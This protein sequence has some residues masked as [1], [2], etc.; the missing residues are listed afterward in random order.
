MSIDVK[1]MLLEGER[2]TLECK[3][4]SRCVPGSVWN[5]YSAFANTNGGIILLGV[6]EN[7]GVE[8]IPGRFEI[9]GVEDADKIRKDFWNTINSREKVNVN[10]LHD[11]DVQMVEVDGKRVVEPIN[12]P[13]NERQLAI[14]AA[15]KNAP[16]LTRNELAEKVNLSLATLKREMASLRENGYIS[17]DGSN[18][19]GQWIILKKK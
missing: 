10:L 2:A 6:A 1:N 14:L 17:R 16:F 9:A 12:E 15:I 18:K 4:A 19:T 13:I 11:E 7:M 8:E 5:T 3:K